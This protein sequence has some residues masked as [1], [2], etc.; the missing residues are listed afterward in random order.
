MGNKPAVQQKVR[1]YQCRTCDK[2]LPE[3]KCLDARYNDAIVYDFVRHS[4]GHCELR[5]VFCSRECIYKCCHQ[6]EDAAPQPVNKGDLRFIHNSI[7]KLGNQI[8]QL[9]ETVDRQERIL[10]G[11]KPFIRDKDTSTIVLEIE[12]IASNK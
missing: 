2:V 4:W 3:D 8:K 9:Q 10:Q 11:L 6:V 1:E 5:G 7:T 12:Q